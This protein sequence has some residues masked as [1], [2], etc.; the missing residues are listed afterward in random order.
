MPL[1]R[2]SIKNGLQIRDAL[3][4]RPFSQRI[5]TIGRRLPRMTGA[6]IRLEHAPGLSDARGDVHAGSFLRERRIAFNCTAREFPRIFVHELFHFVWLRL[7]NSARRSWEDVMHAERLVCAHGE[8]G[9]SAEWRQ[10]ALR[11]V[12]TR[13][14]S[15]A[16]RLYCC[17]SFCDTAA[18]MYSGVSRHAEFT[19]AGKYRTRRRNWFLATIATRELSI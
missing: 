1:P 9:W 7:G 4:K 12:D 11:P 3:G 19:L 16:W 6:P 13:R 17:E 18:W 15:R 14:R 2:G 10:A 5:Q 8:L